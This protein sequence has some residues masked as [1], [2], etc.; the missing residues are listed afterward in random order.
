[1]P[2][3]ES[4]YQHQLFNLWLEPSHR[5]RVRVR[6]KRT[7]FKAKVAGTLMMVTDPTGRVVWKR[8]NLDRKRPN[9]WQTITYEFET[10]PELERSGIYLYNVVSPDIAWFDDL[11]VDDLGPSKRAR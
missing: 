4:G 6:A 2:P 10:P 11:R 5:Y 8:R 7:G 3:T 9:E 1:L